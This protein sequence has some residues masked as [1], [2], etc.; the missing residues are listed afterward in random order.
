LSNRNSSARVAGA[1]ALALPG[2]LTQSG[3]D[4]KVRKVSTPRYPAPLRHLRWAVA[5][6]AGAAAAVTALAGS[7][8]AAPATASGPPTDTARPIV[9]TDPVPPGFTSWDQVLAVQQRIDAVADRIEEAAAAPGVAGFG[10]LVSEPEASRLRLYW[11]GALPAS[12]RA[13][14]ARDTA[15]SV[16]VERAAFTDAELQAEIS[17][18]MATQPPGSITDPGT[19]VTGAAPQADAS[20]LT[21][22]VNGSMEAGRALPVVQG[23]RVPVTVEGGVAPRGQSRGDDSR[24]YYGGAKWTLNGTGG[25][26]TGFAVRVGGVS[27]M[28]SAGHCADSDGQFAYDGGFTANDIMGR[29]SISSDTL[30]DA[31]LIDTPSAGVV[32]NGGVG[33]GEFAN[34]VAGRHFNHRGDFVCTSGAFSGTRCNIKI[35]F[36]NVTQT[37]SFVGKPNRTFNRLV[38]AEQQSHLNSS[39]GGDSGG[40]VFEVDPIDNSVVWAKG[41]ITGGDSIANPAS[42]TGITHTENGPRLC[43]WRTWYTSIAQSLNSFGGEI[44]IG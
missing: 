42:C 27:K 9:I 30:L 14:L 28:L 15:G 17:R 21:V 4:E 31:L 40:P 6:A 2:P 11:K 1:A 8:A 25:C 26:S 38:L 34:G 13:L 44:A 18:I 39:G 12:I 32:Y 24:P 43:S 16:V 19:R 22:F 29:V 23:A 35:A 41:T 10:S 36:T 5:V 33:S 3:H 37:F 7:A 20:G